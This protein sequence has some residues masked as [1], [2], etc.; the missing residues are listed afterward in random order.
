M[1]ISE[2]DYQRLND[3]YK[4]LQVKLSAYHSRLLQRNLL[5]SAID[6]AIIVTDPEFHITYWNKAAEKLYGW[7]AEEVIGKKSSDLVRTKSLTN[8]RAGAA[9]KFVETGSFQGE[10]LQYRRDGTPIRVESNGLVIK[11]RQGKITGFA[12][13]N[14][15]VTGQID[16]DEKLQKGKINF[17]AL[18]RIAPLGIFQ[19]NVKGEIIY[20][21]WR[22]SELMDLNLNEALG[23]GWL[24][25][26]YP[27][28]Q[29]KVRQ[30]WENSVLQ[31]LPFS[32]EF[33]FLHKN[34][35]VVY[36]L[37]QGSA[38]KDR[39]GKVLSYIGTLTDITALKE[40][41]EELLR[42]RNH[43]EELVKERTSELQVLNAKLRWEN[44]QKKQFEYTLSLYQ[45]L[46]KFA[47]DG[48]YSYDF[49]SGE[50]LS[51]NEG[52]VKILELDLKP[53]ELVGK[54]NKGYYYLCFG[55][56]QNKK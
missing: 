32:F 2:A 47:H 27:E 51:A 41:Q 44:I 23:Y 16:N 38:Q 20:L 55:R 33:R 5:L 29:P 52:L 35:R 14:R 34:G 1:G 36:V 39:K 46:W 50:I 42:Y 30:E 17:E 8:K 21:N 26:V 11:D 15:D 12:S 40:V 56:R 9:Q 18:A 49:E 48:I 54:K 19:S 7:K 25:A 31:G 43:L 53:E 22:G 6:E 4:E 45:R 37:A 10:V 3:L 13:I 28:D 24:Q